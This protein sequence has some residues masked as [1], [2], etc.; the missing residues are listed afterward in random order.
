MKTKIRIELI[1]RTD[2][3]RD[4]TPVML[5]R[6]WCAG[7]AVLETRRYPSELVRGL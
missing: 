1:Y 6:I 4:G 2:V 7:E 5:F 3:S